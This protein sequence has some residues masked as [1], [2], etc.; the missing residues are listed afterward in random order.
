MG[1]GT[2]VIPKSA[3]PGRIE[4]NFGSLGCELGYEALKRLEKVGVKY[5]T[6]FNNPS[7]SW[8]V[9]LYGGLDDS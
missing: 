2:S 9:D 3:H 7:K 6:R 8:G 1:R 4:E 5:L